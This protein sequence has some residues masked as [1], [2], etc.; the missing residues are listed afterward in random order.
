MPKPK[1]GTHNPTG[2]G[3]FQERPQDIHPGGWKKENSIGYQY[4][5]LIK[6]SVSEFDNWKRKYPRKIRTM[7][8]E[9]AYQAVIS[10]IYDIKYLEEVTDRTEGKAPQ[11]IEHEGELK[12]TFDEKQVE[13]IADRISGRKR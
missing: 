6:L 7:A 8:Q 10:S 13:R 2:K 9:I 3:G 5:M 4:R 12:H 11:V 1:G